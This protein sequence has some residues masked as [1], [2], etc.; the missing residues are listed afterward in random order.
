MAMCITMDDPHGAISGPN[1]LLTV[2][3]E[4]TGCDVLR[5]FVVVVYSQQTKCKS[6]YTLTVNSIA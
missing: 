1:T 6:T 3:L 5:L 2:I 4:E